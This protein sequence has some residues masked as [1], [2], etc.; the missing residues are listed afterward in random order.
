MPDK[1][2]ILPLAAR[3]AGM[4]EF[5]YSFALA[6]KAMKAMSDWRCPASPRS[7]ELFYSYALGHDSDL[8]E[9]VSLLASTRGSIPAAVVDRLWA[10]YCSPAKNQKSID[11]IS[12]QLNSQIAEV[13][14]MLSVSA[15]R[16][17]EYS[18]CLDTVSSQLDTAIDPDA[19]RTV[20][21]S[22]VETTKEM[23]AYSQQMDDHLRDSRQ[24]IATLQKDL[25]AVR[26]EALTDR[27]TGIANRKHFEERLALEISAAEMN[28]DDLCLLIGD[29]DFFKKFN[30]SYG[31]QTG[32]QVL[33]LVGQALISGLKGRDLAA[34]YGGEEFAIILPATSL[35]AAIAVGNNIRTTIRTKELV[36]KSSGENLGNITMS[37]GAAQYRRGEAADSLI[38]RADGCLYAAKRGGR[39]MVI[40]EREVEKGAHSHVA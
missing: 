20:I 35:D 31:H 6:R 7:F 14:D 10:K 15:G 32:D 29:I 8:V 2:A 36:R 38:E 4:E 1:H 30:D 26:N 17:T 23:N 34:R 3:L 25:E 33:R 39:N 16:T 37:F 27:L 5:D 22:L 24:Q 21:V 13:I 40:S 11:D 12:T 18:E 9:E 19:L 28:G